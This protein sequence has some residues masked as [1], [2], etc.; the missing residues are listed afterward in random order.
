MHQDILRLIA[1][2]LHFFKEF[3]ILAQQSGA[4]EWKHDGLMEAVPDAV[5]TIFSFL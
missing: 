5:D 4:F 2:T 1:I 3:Y